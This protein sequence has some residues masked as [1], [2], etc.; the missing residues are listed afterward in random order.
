MGHGARQEAGEDAVVSRVKSWHTLRAPSS[1]TP[2]LSSSGMKL[3]GGYQCS[4]TDA[5]YDFSADR[6]ILQS[7]VQLSYTYC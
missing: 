3:A 1:T 4:S 5:F 6:D 2:T 7:W